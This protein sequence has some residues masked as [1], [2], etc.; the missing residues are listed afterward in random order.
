M[1]L[2]VFADRFEVFLL[3]RIVGGLTE[4]N[5][6]MSI[7]MISDISD[8]SNRSKA[9]VRHSLYRKTQTL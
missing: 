2:W 6:Q 9:L 3:S 7:A 8:E 5:V 1:G 4:G